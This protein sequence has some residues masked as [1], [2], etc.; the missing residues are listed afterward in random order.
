MAVTKRNRRQARQHAFQVIY[1]HEFHDE[2][3]AVSYPDGKEQGNMDT[4]YATAMVDGVLAHVTELDAII[5]EHSLKRKVEHLDKV[6]RSVLRLAIWEMK[7]SPEPLDPSIA[8]NEA[9]QLAK[10]F[11]SDNS[12][13]LVN[14]ILD[15]VVKGK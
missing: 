4:T 14:G 3:S 11:G 7:F 12:Y 9:I 8:I 5:Q 10:D 13:K 1:A 15:G 2:P 6:D